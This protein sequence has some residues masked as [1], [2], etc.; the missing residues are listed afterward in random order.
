MSPSVQH[1]SSKDLDFL[2][3]LAQN[4]ARHG[5]FDPSICTNRQGFRHYLSSAI[6]QQVDPQGHPTHAFVARIGQVRVGAA[7]VTRA[8]G[9]PDTGME[10]ALIALKAEYRGQGTGRFMLDSILREYLPRGSVYARCFPASAQLRHMLLRR[11]FAEV[12]ALG[13][14]AILRH[15]AVR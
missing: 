4:G 14:A 10:L 15:G 12:G 5:H 3:S 2:M 7:M 1:A 9:T 8:L 6:S 13:H 11:D